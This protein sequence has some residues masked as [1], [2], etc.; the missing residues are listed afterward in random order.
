[1][2]HW[3]VI[4]MISIMYESVHALFH[5]VRNIDL[6]AGQHLFLAGDRVNEVYLV[7]SGC[8]HLRRHTLQGVSI[9]LQQAS[10]ESI[11]AEASVYSSQYHCDAVAVEKT[12]VAALPATRFLDALSADPALSAAWSAM[13]ARGVQAARLRAEIRTLHRVADR[14]DAW[15]GEGNVLPERGRWQ[16]TASELG[17]TREAFYRELARRR[18]GLATPAVKP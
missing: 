5:T 16:D 6:D 13:L 1:M 12:R 9:V 18:T 7:R 4:Y 17:V 15:L 11:I 10:V 8:V 14:L 3:P 2:H